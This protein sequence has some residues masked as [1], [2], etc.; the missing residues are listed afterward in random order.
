MKSRNN[1]G[2]KWLALPT[3]T[4][5]L[6]GCLNQP[7]KLKAQTSSPV[8]PDSQPAA[9]VSEET[10]VPPVTVQNDVTIPQPGEI[11]P[12]AHITQFSPG[13]DDIVKLAQS[14][15][16]EEV[17]LAYIRNANRKYQPTSDEIVYL[18]DL[19]VADSVI[20]ELLKHSSPETQTAAGDRSISP[21]ASE[22]PAVSPGAVIHT[23]IADAAAAPSYT[24]TTPVVDTP[25]AEDATAPAQTQV[26]I[27]YFQSSLAPYG[28]WVEVPDYGMVWRPT[29][30]VLNP[31]WR[32]YWD[33]GRWLYTDHGWYWHSDYSWGWAT[34]HYGRWHH[35]YRYGW[36]WVPGHV[37]APAWVSW[38]YSPAYC[39]WAPLPPTAHYHVGVGFS[40]YR[41]RVSPGFDFGLHY[42]H[43]NFVPIHHFHYRHFHRH[44][45]PHTH[46]TQVYN[47]TTVINNY[48]VGNNNTVINQGFGRDQI[49]KVTRQEIPKAEIRQ[50]PMRAA[51]GPKTERIER[52]GDKLVVYKPTIPVSASAAGA[53]AI[54]ARGGETAH[55]S[56][57]IGAVPARS[58]G[59][60]SSAARQE[61]SGARAGGPG[62]RP[63]QAIPAQQ[64]SGASP[65]EAAAPQPGI[66]TAGN[67]S[68]PRRTVLP[69]SAAQTPQ[70]AAVPAPAARIPQQGNSAQAA[71]PGIPS[72]RNPQ[73]RAFG[74]DRVPVTPQA[75]PQV[76]APQTASPQPRIPAQPRTLLP[77][78]AHPSAPVAQAAP[79]APTH[80]PAAPVA[81]AQSQFQP[82]PRQPGIPAQ[83]ASPAPRVT[84]PSASA[85]L[86]QPQTRSPIAA[87]SPGIPSTVQ[88]PMHAA[89]APAAPAPQM[90]ME[91][92]PQSIPGAIPARP[93]PQPS[94]SIPRPST[95]APAPMVAPR[96]MAPAPSVSI[97]QRAPT[98]SSPSVSSGIPSRGSSAPMLAPAAP[99]AQSAPA[100]RQQGIPSRNR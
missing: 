3:V 95:P 24:V 43:Y 82:I 15:V 60:P 78:P 14:G 77:S 49:T 51:A 66:P 35:S 29:V 59:I 30:V 37:W 97:P 33:R 5:A 63:N 80:A 87:P 92:R 71:T 19:G 44:R 12:P 75:A 89:P 1:W 8:I 53:G 52:E 58:P 74:T 86:Y 23:R 79:S 98:P 41:T 70:S 96:P 18:T 34:F 13:L 27:Q 22:T 100:Q 48:V 93:A 57:A 85:P 16:S 90:R 99:P 91:A 9:P 62:A 36:V 38:R 94:V 50:I 2:L 6:L 65:V 32:P 64:L 42:T 72:G 61:A 10:G 7:E 73:D 81:P 55:S 4:V 11:V 84:A 20:A 45:V 67:R 47:Q 39:G 21:S 76:A 25:A 69:Q 88:R 26:T 28:T 54:R 56:E 46:V 83:T 68:E 17:L 31:H 40:Y